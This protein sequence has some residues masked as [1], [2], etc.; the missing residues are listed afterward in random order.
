[1]TGIFRSSDFE[2]LQHAATVARNEDGSVPEYVDNRL[3]AL[4]QELDIEMD[5]VAVPASAAAILNA[6][7]SVVAEY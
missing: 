3:R 6:I 2:Y 5:G 1:M 4:C 7:R